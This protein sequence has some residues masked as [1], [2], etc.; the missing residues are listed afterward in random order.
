MVSFEQQHLLG[1][2]QRKL[3]FSLG[4]KKI[5]FSCDLVCTYIAVKRVR[6]VHGKMCMP[7]REVLWGLFP[8]KNKVGTLSA[9]YVLVLWKNK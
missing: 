2:W 1:F 7:V 9:S 6:P 8:E 3:E 5:L 4:P